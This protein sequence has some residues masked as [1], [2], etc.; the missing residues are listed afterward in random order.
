MND[1]NVTT[2]PEQPAALCSSD[3]LAC[4][5][6][7]ETYV[8][9]LAEIPGGGCQVMCRGCGARSGVGKEMDVINEWNRRAA[10]DDETRACAEIG[11]RWRENS[12]LEEWFPFSAQKLKTLE[13]EVG[14]SAGILVMQNRVIRR[15]A[16]ELVAAIER[17]NELT[18]ADQIQMLV[19]SVEDAI[20][21]AEMAEHEHAKQANAEV[22]ASGVNNPQP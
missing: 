8:S 7:S 1:Q 9:L 17:C 6:C 20:G 11:K 14:N 21:A 2:K 22:S 13:A 15:L 18:P 4:P 5:H 19:P 16:G 3:L 12:G 10:L